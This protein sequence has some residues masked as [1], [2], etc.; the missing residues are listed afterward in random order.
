MEREADHAR[1][2]H[3]RNRGPSSFEK[4][5]RVERLARINRDQLGIVDV[6]HKHMDKF[7][8]LGDKI[9]DFKDET[10]NLS[11]KFIMELEEQSK[12]ERLAWMH[13]QHEYE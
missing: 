5:E 6:V 9:H 3:E 13:R 2:L 12:K 8:S 7:G 4:V 1:S 10:I 11:K